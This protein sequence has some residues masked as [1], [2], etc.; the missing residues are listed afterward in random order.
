MTSIKKIFDDASSENYWSLMVIARDTINDQDS[1][2]RLKNMHTIAQ[3]ECATS[4]K[5]ISLC[6][7]NKRLMSAK[8]RVDLRRCNINNIATDDTTVLLTLGRTRP[9]TDVHK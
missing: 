4:T 7:S 9:A 1:A 6:E 5:S 2:L 3:A 8:W